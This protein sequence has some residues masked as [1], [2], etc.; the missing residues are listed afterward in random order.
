MLLALIAVLSFTSGCY[1]WFDDGYEVE[2]NAEIKYYT[3]NSAT[4]LDSLERGN[5]DIFGLFETTPKAT[6]FPLSEPVSWDQADFLQIAQAFYKQFWQEPLGEQNVY[7]LSFDLDCAKIKQGVF[8]EAE[9]L[10]FKVIGNGEEET[11]IQYRIRIVPSENLVYTSKA[12]YRPNLNAK[13]PI[14]LSQYRIT[15]EAALQIAE[16][17]GGAEKRLE[18]ENDCRI[19]ALAPGPKGKGWRVL[20][21]NNQDQWW[22]LFFEIAIDPQTGA[23]EVLY[24]KP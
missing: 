21:Q 15:A 9:I 23:F 3:I 10:S 2:S 19:S 17:N 20:Y 16:K 18:F 7:N 4:I 5:I 8:S 6:S 1:G 14:D 11:R 22:T 24:R 13:E 12:E